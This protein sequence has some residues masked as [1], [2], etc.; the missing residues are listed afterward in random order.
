M[1]LIEKLFGP[2]SKYHKDLPY[3]YEALIAV[4][5]NGEITNS[6]L[7]DTICGLIERLQK[8][9]VDPTAVEI[10]EVYRDGESVVDRSY[11]AAEDGG[12]LARPMLCQSLKSQYPGHITETDCS[13]S[14]R[15]NEVSG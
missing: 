7:S 3:T 11:Y 6:L 14:D 8:D 1:S 9:G 5:E 13:F 4:T 12:W 10:R 2:R 15:D